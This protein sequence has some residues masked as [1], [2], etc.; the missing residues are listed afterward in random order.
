MIVTPGSG[1]NDNTTCDHPLSTSPSSQWNTYFKDN[2]VLLQIDK[3]VRFVSRLF[4]IL[5]ICYPILLS[6]LTNRRLNPEISFF[7]QA[8]DYPC[9]S[10]V[11]SGGRKRL[12]RRVQNSL[13]NSANVERKG[14][15]PT[16]VGN[17]SGSYF[18]S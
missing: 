1:S 7:Q 4:L 2:E 5:V 3:D 12:H 10:V 14:L 13:L 16:T 9:D 11:N 17:H 8:T 6:S 18:R 15:G